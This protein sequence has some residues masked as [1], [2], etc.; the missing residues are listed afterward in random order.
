MF[1][2][3]VIVT[4]TF[5]LCESDR[6]WINIDFLITIVILMTNVRLIELYSL[7]G[8]NKGKQKILPKE[9]VP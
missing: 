2:D 8:M 4:P 3:L 1:R 7:G 9:P 5:I 6:E